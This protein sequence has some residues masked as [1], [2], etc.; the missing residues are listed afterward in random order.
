ME[1]NNFTKHPYSTRQTHFKL[2][3]FKLEPISIHL[4]IYIKYE[5]ENKKWWAYTISERATLTF[6][7]CLN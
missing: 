5:A 4:K 1:L 3:L 6:E 7:I 2:S